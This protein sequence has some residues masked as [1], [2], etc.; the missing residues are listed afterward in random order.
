MAALKAAGNIVVLCDVTMEAVLCDVTT[1][2]VLCDV[3]M[4]AVLC[5][6]TMEAALCDVTMEAVFDS[7]VSADQSLCRHLLSSRGKERPTTM[8]G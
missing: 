1:E 2:A 4:E 6:V 7:P 3:T 5:D 8:S